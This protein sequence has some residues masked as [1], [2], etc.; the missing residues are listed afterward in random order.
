MLVLIIY[1]IN[2]NVISAP[3][4]TQQR[5]VMNCLNIIILVE[6]NHK[7]EIIKLTKF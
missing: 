1:H 3:E 7:K 4:D 2:M 5:K 6:R